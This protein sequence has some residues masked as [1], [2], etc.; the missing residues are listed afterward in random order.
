MGW[1]VSDIQEYKTENDVYNKWYEVSD[2]LPMRVSNSNELIF[3][4]TFSTK[5]EAMKQFDCGRSGFTG[6][7]YVKICKESTKL[8]NAIKLLE[9]EKK[10]LSDYLVDSSVYKTHT[11][12]T[13]GCKKCGSSF[14]VNYFCKNSKYRYDERWLDIVGEKKF[15]NHCPICL[16]EMRSDTALKR[17]EGYKKNIEKYQKR[18]DELEKENNVRYIAKVNAYC[19]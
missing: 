19:G 4:G 6:M 14:P 3:G 15:I 7:K 11:G 2:S 13:V 18:V 5:A 12:K 1:L 9:N 8:K 10:K 17:I 16:E